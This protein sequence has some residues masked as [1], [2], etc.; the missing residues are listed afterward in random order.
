LLIISQKY[1]RPNEQTP[2]KW[3]SDY[4]DYNET[5]ATAGADPKS[6]G[7]NATKIADEMRSQPSA[8]GLSEK[9]SKADVAKAPPVAPV[10]DDEMEDGEAEVKPSLVVENGKSKKRKHD[11]ETAEERAERKRKKKEKKEAK[12]SKKSKKQ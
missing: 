10:S 5:P 2:A 4:K 6:S 8:P 9:T 12:E 1:G 7:A 3:N 11:D